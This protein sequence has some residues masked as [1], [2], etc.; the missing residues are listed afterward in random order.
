[1]NYKISECVEVPVDVYAMKSC[2][3]E[4]YPIIFGLKLTKRFFDPGPQG[5]LT[6]QH[7]QLPYQC[8]WIHYLTYPFASH[9]FLLCLF[10]MRQVL[11]RL[12]TPTTLSLLSTASMQCFVWD[13]QMPT[14]CKTH[15]F[16]LFSVPLIVNY[17]ILCVCL[18]V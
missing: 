8:A 11:L 13:T 1:M 7:Q 4:G 5:I 15:V 6:F 14:K 2:L 18:P 3:A 16:L 12:P 9:F 17:T 10:M